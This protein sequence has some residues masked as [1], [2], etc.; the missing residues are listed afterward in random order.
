MKAVLPLPGDIGVPGTHLFDL[1]GVPITVA[2]VV[3][4][5]LIVLVSLLASWGVRS[6]L[7]HAFHRRGVHAEGNLVATLRLLHYVIL[8]LG[9]VIGLET[10][11]LDLAAFFAAGVIFAIAIGF[12]LQNIVQNFVSGMILLFE[13][14]I[15]PG[16]I[17]RLNDAVVRVERMGIRAT[18]VRTLDDEDVIVPN[19]TL[20]QSLVTNFTLRDSIHRLQTTVGVA[21][22]AEVALAREALQRAAEGVPWRVQSKPPVVLLTEFGNSAVNFEVSVWIEDPWKMRAARSE[23]NEAIWR[24]L[25]EARATI[26]SPQLAGG[27]GAGAQASRAGSM[28]PAGGA[29]PAASPGSEMRGQP[30]A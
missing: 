16:D 22:G 19:S 10:I 24:G 20:V 27:G 11:G 13:R 7:R 26:A 17:L 25:T 4:F 2:S 18:M 8:A 29:G 3:V 5:G 15:T 9:I 23:L 1:S 21:Y 6:S 14:M 30:S 28:S 12:A